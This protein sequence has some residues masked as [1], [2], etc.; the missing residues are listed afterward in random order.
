[1]NVVLANKLPQTVSVHLRINGKLSEVRIP[2]NGVSMPVD[3]KALAEHA[4]A[5][6]ASGHLRVRKA[7]TPA[8]VAEK[9]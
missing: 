6:V 8:P 3:Q 1:M 2:P 5:L 7:A 9:A 4:N